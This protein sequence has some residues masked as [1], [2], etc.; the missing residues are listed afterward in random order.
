MT[1]RLPALLLLVA[2]AEEPEVC[3]HE[4]ALTYESFGRGF[5]EGYCTGC[6]SSIIPPNQ[7]NQAPPDVNLDTYEGVLLWADR[8]QQ[9]TD[10]RFPTMP[11]GGGPTTPEYELFQEWLACEVLPDA[12]IYWYEDAL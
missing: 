11:P 1:R 5:M 3:G 12:E 10:P 8:V 4:P 7:R 6:H 9:Q 2:C